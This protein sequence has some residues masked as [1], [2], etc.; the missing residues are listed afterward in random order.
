MNDNRVIAMVD[1]VRG[2]DSTG[3][4][5]LLLITA[6]L[7]LAATGCG[8]DA[9][10]PESSAER[11][12]IKAQSG[13]EFEQPEG[14]DHRAE[15]SVVIREGDSNHDQIT[16]NQGAH[17]EFSEPFEQVGWMMGADSVDGMEYRGRI[18]G[19]YTDWKLLQ[20]YFSEGGLHNAHV[21]FDTP[22]DALQWRVDEDIDFAEVA[23][24]EEVTARDEII[25]GDQRQQEEAGA[26]ESEDEEFSTIAQAVAPDDLVTDRNEWDAIDPDKVC[27]QV[28]DPWRATIHH[29]YNPDSDGVDA[30][31]RVRQM[32]S[33]HINTEGWCD[34]GYHFVV[35]QSG[36]I[37]QGRSHS[38]RPGAH[39]LGENQGNVGIALI[40][41]YMSS[42]PGSAQIDGAVDILHWVHEQHGVTL[43]SNS[44][45]GHR[46]WPDQ[47]TPCPGDVGIDYV[48]DIIDG[49]VDE[50]DDSGDSGSGDDSGKDDSGGTSGDDS[51]GD[52][53]GSSTIPEDDGDTEVDGCSCAAVGEGPAGIVVGWLPVLLVLG[54]VALRS[55]WLSEVSPAQ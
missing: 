17:F 38:D 48:D 19:E 45:R 50:A 12:D 23:F 4:R 42:A 34:I 53:D 18:D 8:P 44:V 11:A 30:G 15:R 35:A 5:F 32:Q 14:A 27:G 54:L 51:G 36:E 2:D 33:Y 28:V 31:D 3:V 1:L 47:S 21:I 22:A 52:D 6:A 49:A 25:T 39:V 9:A 46:D 13:L 7:L 41:D 55:R 10:Q 43:D 40:G 16:G 29:T 37:F 24:S 20:P 26:P